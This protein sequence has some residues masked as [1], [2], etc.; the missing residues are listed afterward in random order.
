M[1]KQPRFNFDKILAKW[2]Q[3]KKILATEVARKAEN[4]FKENFRQGGFIDDYLQKWTPRK[5]A[6]PGRAIL[7]KSGRLK[8][9]IKAAPGENFTRIDI[10]NDVPYAKYHNEGT[11]KLPQR[12]FIGESKALNRKIK[13]AVVRSVMKIFR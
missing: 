3:E 4:Q 6:D 10:S 7:V 5:N 13:E 8:R 1:A 12:K 2:E 9:G 11:D